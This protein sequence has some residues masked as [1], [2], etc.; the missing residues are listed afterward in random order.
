[1][2]QTFAAYDIEAFKTAIWLRL[3]NL[4]EEAGDTKIKMP[5]GIFL[6]IDKEHGGDA[7]AEEIAKRFELLDFESKN[8][9]DFYFFGWLVFN[10]AWRDMAGENKS[11][12]AFNLKAFENCRAALRD[13]GITQFGGNADLIIFDAYLDDNWQVVLDFTKVIHIDLAKEMAERTFSTL[14]G[15]LE[16]LVEVA[17]SVRSDARIHEN[18]NLTFQISDKLGIAF[19]KESLLE[20]LLDKL[21][22][23]IGGKRLSKLTTERLGGAIL[24][25][26]FE[27]TKPPHM[28][29][30]RWYE[31]MIEKSL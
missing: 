6:L 11:G 15:F 12:L 29:K 25:D 28:T 22:K 9:I 16:I 17:E 8:V 13:I 10:N 14:G 26:A 23:I 27:K 5:T 24:L 30:Q 31:R 7:T 20:Y 1:M 18:I 21:G 2:T 4:Q 3:V 19:A